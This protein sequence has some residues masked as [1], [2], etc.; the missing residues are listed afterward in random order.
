MVEL[1][2]ELN[3]FRLSFGKDKNVELMVKVGNDSDKTRTIS[4]EIILSEHLAFEKNGRG[5]SKILRMGKMKPGENKIN[6]FN[7]FPKISLT[8]R[9]Q[10]ISI[11]A[12]E[13][14]EDKYDYILG[15]KSKTIYLRV[16]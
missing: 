1:K 5:T 14:F 4:C 10:P 8:K 15:K 12:I 16:E 6:Y 7:I 13:H 3:P 2:T 9:E 11:V